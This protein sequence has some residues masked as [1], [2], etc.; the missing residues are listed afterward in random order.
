MHPQEKG[1][2]RPKGGGLWE[3]GSL[4]RAYLQSTAG[5]EERETLRPEQQ[6]EPTHEGLGYLCRGSYGQWGFSEG[7]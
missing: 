2:H 4:G 1:E 7:P 6:V 5:E 3:S